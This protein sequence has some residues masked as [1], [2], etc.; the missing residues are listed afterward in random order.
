MPEAQQTHELSFGI[1][2]GHQVRSSL[3]HQQ[4]VTYDSATQWSDPCMGPIKIY[5]D[6]T[7]IQST[8][9]ANNCC[10]HKLIFS[11]S[12]WI[13]FWPPWLGGIIISPDVLAT[14]KDQANQ[15]E[16]QSWGL[17]CCQL[18]AGGTG[19]EASRTVQL[20]RLLSRCSPPEPDRRPWW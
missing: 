13:F 7:N 12:L 10:K 14:T 19:V 4:N 6:I 18:A 17:C 8:T 15:L 20:R 2:V 1:K 9:G 16:L 3:G 5:T 11:M